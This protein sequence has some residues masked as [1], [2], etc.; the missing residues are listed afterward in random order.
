M[1]HHYDKF[2]MFI[3]FAIGGSRRRLLCSWDE[4]CLLQILK[5]ID[6]DCSGLVCILDCLIDGATKP[7]LFQDGV[8]STLDAEASTWHFLNSLLEFLGSCL[9]SNM[10]VWHRKSHLICEISVTVN[11]CWIYVK[12][13]TLYLLN[14]NGIIGVTAWLYCTIMNKNGIHFKS[15]FSQKYVTV[16]CMYITIYN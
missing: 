12:Y 6:W 15:F 10:K 7:I 3:C 1:I 16:L 9:H 5:W 8:R 14:T 2:T 13:V 11:F 4:T